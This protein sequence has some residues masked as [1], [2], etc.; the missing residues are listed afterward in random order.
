MVNW[1]DTLPLECAYAAVDP[2][3]GV[4]NKKMAFTRGINAI[5]FVLVT[6]TGT[7]FIQTKTFTAGMFFIS[8][9]HN[10]TCVIFICYFQIIFPIDCWSVW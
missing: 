10:L 5:K 2:F 4:R 6:C 1:G 9:I 8:C 3:N 7:F